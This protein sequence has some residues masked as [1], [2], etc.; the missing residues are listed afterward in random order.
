MISGSMR[1]DLGLN[2][3]DDGAMVPA[4]LREAAEQPVY[5]FKEGVH[6]RDDGSVTLG[7]LVNNETLDATF[8][9]SRSAGLDVGLMMLQ[10]FP[11]YGDYVGAMAMYSG[12]IGRKGYDD[13][14]VV[15]EEGAFNQMKGEA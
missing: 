15:L 3:D 4:S 5:P 6:E 1:E 14:V 10:T 8:D 2:T 13:K 11:T 9:M 12:F 7:I